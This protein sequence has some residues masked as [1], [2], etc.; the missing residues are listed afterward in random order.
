MLVYLIAPF[1]GQSRYWQFED[2]MERIATAVEMDLHGATWTDKVLLL[3]QQLE[4]SRQ[5]NRQLVAYLDEKDEEIENLNRQLHFYRQVIAPED[6]TGDQLEIFSFKLR[7]KLK[8]G[9]YPVEVVVR[10]SIKEKTFSKGEVLIHTEGRKGQKTLLHK[11]SLIEPMP[12][13]FRYFQ[14]LNGFIKPPEGLEPSTVHATVV[15]GDKERL[16]EA[17]AWQK[18]L[19]R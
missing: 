4:T 13:S 6:L 15:L 18:L 17:Y 5:A 7:Q 16:T 11:D 9:R 3:K 19:A 8:D 14:R 1:I 10:K 2:E 12:F